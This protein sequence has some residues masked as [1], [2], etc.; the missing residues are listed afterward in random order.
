[1]F[2]KKYLYVKHIEQT[3]HKETTKR[4]VIKTKLIAE[5]Y[6]SS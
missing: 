2:T 5:S 6:L 1:M 3:N 4:F